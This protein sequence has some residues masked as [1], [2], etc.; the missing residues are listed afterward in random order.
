MKTLKLYL[1]V[2][3]V[4]TLTACDSTLKLNDKEIKVGGSIEAE[5]EELND[6]NSRFT[7]TDDPSKV[8]PRVEVITDGETGCK[9]I[10]TISSGAT[11]TPLLKD[12]KPDC[13]TE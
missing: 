1:L 10:M 4:L 7:V 2:A 6:S 5:G 9:Y 12:G 3:T 11:L 13:G 8:I